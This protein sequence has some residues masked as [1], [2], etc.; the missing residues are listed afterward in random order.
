MNDALRQPVCDVLDHLLAIQREGVRPREARAGLQDVRG[1]HPDLE[2]D[3]L[4]EEQAFDGSF[5][6]DALIRQRGGGTVSLSYCP[7]RAVPWPLRG[8]HRWSEGDLVRVN[9][10]VLQVDVA[11]A[12]LD[13]IW[14]EA[15]VIE[16]LVNVCLIQQELERRPIEQTNAELQE[17]MDKFRAA[18]KLFKAEDTV[19]WLEQRG[20]SQEKLERYIADSAI[21]PKLREKIANEKVEEYFETHRSEFDSVRVARLMFSSEGQAREMAET[22]RAGKENFFTASE[23]I[24]FEAAEKGITPKTSLFAV[25]ARRE[26][27]SSFRDQIFSATPGELVGPVAVENGFTLM[28]ILGVV[29]ASLDN[30][31][32][33]VI[34]EIIFK[35]WLVEQRKAATI[36][37]YWGNA[38]TTVTR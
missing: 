28:R 38:Q 22:I 34:K 25:I 13:F 11:M 6:Y 9:D 33:A 23:R 24:F 27:E 12:C 35:D 14:D 15:P 7:E 8:V 37:W 32:R 30:R 18:K 36:E 31:V 4:A 3:L 17:A 1:R 26:A 10:N 21:V 19:K 16:R 29:P 5:H 20:M 2:I